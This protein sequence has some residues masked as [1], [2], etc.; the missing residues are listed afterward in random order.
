MRNPFI[1][2]L[3]AINVSGK[4]RIQMEALRAVYENLGYTQVTSYLQSGNL[5]FDG[6]GQNA[7]QIERRLEAAILAEFGMSIPVLIR[8]KGEIEAI[9]ERSPFD[10][11]EE[12]DPAKLAVVFLKTAPAG[13]AVDALKA[14]KD[15]PEAFYLSGREI[16]VYY[17][18]RL[19]RS[20]LSNNFF[21]SKLGVAATTRNWNTVKALY[22]LAAEPEKEG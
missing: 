15:S 11:Q 18:N 3:R 6:A 20:K 1:S 12:L 14:P 16:F 5:V 2:L 8:S 13:A 10:T 9:L 7:L 4:N 21:E 19:G 17:P 22:A